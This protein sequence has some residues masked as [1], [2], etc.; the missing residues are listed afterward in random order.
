[1]LKKICF[2]AFFLFLI[3][4]SL[5]AQERNTEQA[6]KIFKARVSEILEEKEVGG[7]KEEAVQQKLELEILEGDKKGET[8]IYNG[9]GDIVVA[10]N[11]VYKKGDKV[12]AAAISDHEGNVS[13]Y[14]TDYVRS[15]ALWWLFGLFVLALLLVGRFKG[16]KALLAL[17][18]TFF[19]IIKFIIPGILGG[20]NALLI[21]I[22][23]S[24]LILLAVIYITEGFKELSHLS[25]ASIFASLLL[26]FFISWF[27]TKIA[28]LTGLSGENILPLISLGEKSINFQ[29]LLLAG[30]LIGSLGVLDDVVVSQ[31]ATVKEI[32]ETDPYQ[33]RIEIFKKSYRVGVSHISS[34]VNT[35][36]LAYAG[37]SLPLLILF[38]SGGSAFPS[39]WHIINNEAVATE[40]V[41]TLAGS[42]GIIL[43]V[44]L[45]T[46]LA[47]WWYKR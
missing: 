41:R 34:M 23:G 16:F 44:P 39:W 29:G 19:I 13:Y 46:T 28:Y 31:V 32:V 12:L 1:M 30:I 26:V 27:F 22:L 24:F 33:Q 6:D 35:L 10:D 37:V 9:I 47:V 40:I 14:V 38:I 18:L 36:F 11:Q 15:P 2:L 42:L 17:A 4:F 45:S 20:A 3:P 25:V 43:S 7:E 21:T 8:V 5:G